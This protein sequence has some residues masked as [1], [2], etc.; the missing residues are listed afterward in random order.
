MNSRSGKWPI[1]EPAGT[2]QFRLYKRP[3]LHTRTIHLSA[4]RRNLIIERTPRYGNGLREVRILVSY[5]GA[6]GFNA[7]PRDR[8][9]S[10]SPSKQTQDYLK[11]DHDCCLQH[12]TQLTMH[13]PSN[14]SVLKGKAVPLQAWRGPEGS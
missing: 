14:H 3:T 2:L 5:S 12:S 11:L 7:R 13:K 6:P 10:L 4:I 1:S 8:T 9:H